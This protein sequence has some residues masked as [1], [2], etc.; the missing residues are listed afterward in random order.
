MIPEIDL[1]KIVLYEDD[2]MIAINKPA[3][4]L[5]IP[6]GFSENTHDLKTILEIKFGKLWVV[7]RLDKDTSGIVLFALDADSHKILNVQFDQREIRKEYRAIVYGVAQWKNQS[8]DRALL[9]NGDRSHRTIASTHGKPA[10]TDFEV[11][12]RFPCFSYL[13]AMP[14]T[15]LTHQIRAHLSILAHPILS[16]SLYAKSTMLPDDDVLMP[17]M[18]L[19]A[20]QIS[21]RHPKTE[22]V[23]QLSAPLPQDFRAALE[24]LPAI[25]SRDE[26]DYNQ[27]YN[28]VTYQVNSV[29]KRNK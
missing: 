23:M 28:T 6:G 9:V 27:I 3:G 5:T 13:K 17:R 11:L 15:G 12:H 8:C 21:F 14:H 18:A 24:Q 26:I 16:D 19:H 29:K 1:H 4:V 20:Q 2:C 22:E 7:H 25:T 10:Q